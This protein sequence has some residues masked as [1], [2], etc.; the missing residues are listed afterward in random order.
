MKI[1]GQEGGWKVT[2]TAYQEGGQWLG[3]VELW[4]GSGFLSF[5]TRE[6]Y[7]S[8]ESAC[9]A[10]YALGVISIAETTLQRDAKTYARILHLSL[11]DSLRMRGLLAQAANGVSPECDAADR[12]ILERLIE[13]EDFRQA[14]DYHI[15]RLTE[16]SPTD[17]PAG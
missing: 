11:K 13:A 1:E 15:L 5:Q 16:K 12:D 3:N 8:D 2:A 10:A 9:K 14:L 7:S 4:N 6:T 17:K